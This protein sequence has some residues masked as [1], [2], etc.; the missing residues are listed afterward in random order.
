[1]TTRRRQVGFW[2][3][4][5]GIRLGQ[6]VQPEFLGALVIGGGG[7]L[8]SLW[9]A[10]ATERLNL[11]ESFVVLAASLVG[12]IFAAM[13]LVVSLLSGEYMRWLR[14]ASDGVKGLLAPFMVA[15]GLQVGVVLGS[16]AYR[17]AAS[18]APVQIEK[19]A[20]VLLS[21]LFTFALLDI[22]AVARNVF[23][24]GLLRESVNELEELQDARERKAPGST[25]SV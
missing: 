13:T 12:V 2:A 9:F 6:L 23:V 4:F 5:G 20:F 8:A 15:I 17:L 19:S 1:M 24:H 16:V 7:A 10:S 18:H 21:F 14:H 3:S 11:V 25:G 22:V